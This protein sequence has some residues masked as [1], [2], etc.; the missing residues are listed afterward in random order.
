MIIE[1]L[2]ATGVVSAVLTDEFGNIK[3]EVH[4]HNLVVTLGKSHITSR[5]IGVAQAVNGWMELG[6]GNVAAAAGDSALTAIA[7]SRT[8]LSSYVQSTTTTTNDAVT[9][10][11]TFGA[12]VGTGAVTEAGLFN[13]S[14]AGNL[15]ARTVFS[16]INKGANDTLIITWKITIA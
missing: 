5:L 6:T 13:A 8:A 16:V 7:G 3:Q 15:M 9:A 11:C 2:K 14:S 12:G 1:H 4:D 10:T